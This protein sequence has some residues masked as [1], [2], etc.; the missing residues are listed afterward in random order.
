MRRYAALLTGGA[1][2]L[3]VQ[4]SAFAA[5]FEVDRC[6]NLGNAL[7]APSEG[8]WGHKIRRDYMNAIAAA[9]IDTVRLPVKWSA[10]T[11]EGPDYAIDEDFMARV[12]E[13]IGWAMDEDLNV[14][15]DVHHFDEIY[16]D[17]E[18]ERAKLVALWQQIGAHY[19][20]APDSL[21]FE[22]LNEPR[23]A[24]SGEVMQ[25]VLLEGLATIRETNPERLVMLGGDQW[26]S[27]RGLPTIPATPDDPNIV[28]TF[29]YYDPHAFTHQ[30]ASWAG[31][32]DEDVDWGSAEERAQLE[33][34]ADRAARHAEETGY[35]LF[36]GEYG[37]NGTAKSDV[38][39]K[40]TEAVTAAMQDR[41]I[42]TCPWAFTQTFP[43]WDNE[44]NEWLPGMKE[45]ILAGGE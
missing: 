25:S 34:D 22:V 42:A 23:E 38:R 2:A 15:L 41:G 37:V 32:S 17:P 24:L 39:I 29:H 36:L 7:D 44:A 30:K 26:N 11:G 16:E 1:M 18:G 12:D 27:I 21:V 28:H 6:V 4:A 20:D 13:V 3:A 9:G 45:A 40:W 33:A 31:M 35:P 10:H 19:A 43:V 14:V 8:E 5:D